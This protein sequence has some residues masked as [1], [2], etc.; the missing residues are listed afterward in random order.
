MPF[1]K[2]RYTNKAVASTSV[3]QRPPPPTRVHGVD[4]RYS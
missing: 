4:G 1:I 2:K 3:V